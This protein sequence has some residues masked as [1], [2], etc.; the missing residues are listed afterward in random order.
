MEQTS[1]DDTK[2]LQDCINDLMSVQ[3]L[4]AVWSGQEPSQI[5]ATLLD[6]LVCVLR[7]DFAYARLSA[8]IDGSP[9]ELVRLPQ[10]RTPEGR[11]EQ[12]NRVLE[13]W[14]T[15]DRPDAPFV[16]PNPFGDGTV[17]VAP[18]RL[19]LQDEIG[20]LVAATTRN[21]FPTGGQPGRDWITRG[22]PAGRA[23][24]DC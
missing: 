21:D 8:A 3:A 15:A 13:G 17:S 22:S 23:K 11:P 2:R 10:G 18:F 7:L 20:I 1:D 16:A 5:V 9:I 6:V 14:F 19:R 12:V 24:A 4:P